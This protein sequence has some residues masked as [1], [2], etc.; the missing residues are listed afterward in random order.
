MLNDLAIS[1]K[2]QRL[3]LFQQRFCFLA[4]VHYVAGEGISALVLK[5]LV[6]D[7]ATVE[8]TSK[9][10]HFLLFFLGRTDHTYFLQNG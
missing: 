4:G 6:E 9:I 1:R 5:C 7:V 2:E 3:S 10:C 8:Q